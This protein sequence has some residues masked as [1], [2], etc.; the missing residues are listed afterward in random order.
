[1]SLLE[2][3]RDLAM[4]LCAYHIL[5]YIYIGFTSYN[6]PSNPFSHTQKASYYDYA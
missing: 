1:M 4:D 5:I 2:K 3:R 6:N